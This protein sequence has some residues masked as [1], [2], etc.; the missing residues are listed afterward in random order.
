VSVWEDG[1]NA[2]RVLGEETFDPGNDWHT[3]RFELRGDELRL[4]VDGADVVAGTLDA[5][6]DASTADAEAGLWAQGVQLEVRKVSVH[7][8]PPA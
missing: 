3:Y 1:Y 4:L 8:L 7:S 5:P 2:D 6:I